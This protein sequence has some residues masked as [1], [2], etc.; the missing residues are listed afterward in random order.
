MDT[1]V[2][3]R[4]GWS[5]SVIASEFWLWEKSLQFIAW[6]N[7]SSPWNNYTPCKQG[8]SVGT[9]EL[10]YNMCTFQQMYQLVFTTFVETCTFVLTKDIG[11]SCCN[12]S[13]GYVCMSFVYKINGSYFRILW[14]ASL[15]LTCDRVFEYFFHK[16]CSTTN[17]SYMIIYGLKCII[18][19]LS[20]SKALF[21]PYCFI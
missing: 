19:A 1:L 11:V 13:V 7:A 20:Y 15:I 8:L 3:L 21:G 5:H 10:L 4:V 9:L 6:I 18:M 12:A 16:C 2:F 17:T 14:T